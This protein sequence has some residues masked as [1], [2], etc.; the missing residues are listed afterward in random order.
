L[1]RE[2]YCSHE[3]ACCAAAMPQDLENCNKPTAVWSK[4]FRYRS[5]A[6]FQDRTGSVRQ[7]ALFRPRCDGGARTPT[8][9]QPHLCF[10]VQLQM[11][12]TSP[13]SRMETAGYRYSS[14]PSLRLQKTKTVSASSILQ[15]RQ[16]SLPKLYAQPRC[17]GLCN[18]DG[19]AKVY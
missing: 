16:L 7:Q 2:S 4:R 8:S 5:Q 12:S 13:L 14:G 1:W 15:P 11:L 3:L 18:N 10:R 6:S 19:A 9:V 17:E